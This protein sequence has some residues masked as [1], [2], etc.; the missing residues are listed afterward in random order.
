MKQHMLTF[1]FYK[2]F[3][4]IINGNGIWDMGWDYTSEIFFF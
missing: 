3:L 1:F 2:G 4:I